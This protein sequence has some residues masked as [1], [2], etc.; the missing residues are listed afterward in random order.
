MSAPFAL[1]WKTPR[2]ASWHRNR[3]NERPS[4]V[5]ATRSIRRDLSSAG[6]WAGAMFASFVSIL[7]SLREFVG[8]AGTSS[9]HLG[10]SGCRSDPGCTESPL[11]GAMP[12]DTDGH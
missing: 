8:S 4:S 1:A 9:R 2:L 5:A 6:F 11:H 3:M 12:F 7:N 10:Q